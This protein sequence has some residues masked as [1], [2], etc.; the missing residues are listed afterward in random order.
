MAEK[1]L[2]LSTTD[3]KIAGVCGGIAEHLDIDP[4]IVRI[5]WLCFTLLGVAGLLFYLITWLVLS[6]TK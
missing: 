1:K 2:T 4:S 5:V 3:K 6:A